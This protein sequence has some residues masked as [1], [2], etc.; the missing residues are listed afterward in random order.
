MSQKQPDRSEKAYQHQVSKL[1]TRSL[2][3]STRQLNRLDTRLRQG[4]ITPRQHRKLA[5]DLHREAAEH[6]N[7]RRR[8]LD[9]NFGR[10][11]PTE[12]MQALNLNEQAVQRIARQVGL[13]GEFADLWSQSSP[14]P[15]P[16]PNLS[17]I[18]YSSLPGM[19]AE[20]VLQVLED[21]SPADLLRLSVALPQLFL[22]GEGGIN[23]IHM[24]AVRTQRQQRRPGE[25]PMLVYAIIQGYSV[26]RIRE[27]LDVYEVYFGSDV[28][29][30]AFPN[31]PRFLEAAIRVSRP[32]VV[33]LLLERGASEL[34]RPPVETAVRE[35]YIVYLLRAT[36]VRSPWG[37]ND[38][39]DRARE[40]YIMFLI[41][42]IQ[43]PE[44]AGTKAVV[45][46]I[47]FIF[48]HN[49]PAFVSVFRN[50]INAAMVLDPTNVARERMQRALP[51]LVEAIGASYMAMPNTHAPPG[52]SKETYKTANV[53]RADDAIRFC[54]LQHRVNIEPDLIVRVSD[55]NPRAANV[56]LT[57]MEEREDDIGMLLRVIDMVTDGS[58]DE[59]VEQ[60][61]IPLINSHIRRGELLGRLLYSAI[62]RKN[63]DIIRMLENG[64][65]D[66]PFLPPEQAIFRA[67]YYDDHG[68]LESL[69]NLIRRAKKSWIYDDLPVIVPPEGHRDWVDRLALG[70]YSVMDMAFLFRNYA[71]ARRFIETEQGT[72]NGRYSTLSLKTVDRI[73]HQLNSVALH[74]SLD[75]Y[76]D[77]LENE[78]I[79]DEVLPIQYENVR[80]AHVRHF[81]DVA[82]LLWPVDNELHNLVDSFYE[83]G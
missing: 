43:S 4:L 26:N 27:I 49:D 24:D 73:E 41:L 44:C 45:D 65:E 5:D 3:Q 2:A 14:E 74:D 47:M 6:L 11:V 46:E 80:R 32:E 62:V 21:L 77:W 31:S 39:V 13:D 48:D 1:F 61:L 76:R 7:V 35:S 19:P 50:L 81:F 67:I 71:M 79:P 64:F 70:D 54:I 75:S 17:Q 59:Y 15:P 29:N 51:M 22:Q 8:R 20:L 82:K 33:I 30:T 55:R 63:Q 83:R 53:N 10:A 60:G 12:E 34:I 52:S 66:R 37:H 42:R 18:P 23:V 72:G 57:I 69:N 25:H 78:P 58:N 36:K 16:L 9:V 56:I 68:L 28:V 38:L 40:I